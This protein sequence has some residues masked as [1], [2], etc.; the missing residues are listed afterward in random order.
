VREATNDDP[1]GPSGNLSTYLI[2]SVGDPISGITGLFDPWIR[3]PGW[4]KNQDSLSEM[5]VLNHI[6][7]SLESIFG[8][9]ILKFF[10]ADPGSGIL[11]TLDPGSGIEREGSGILINIPD[12]QHC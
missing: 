12:T 2:G 8:L 3:D 9:K 6:S 7:E 5:N 1:W 10:D 11:L 4:V